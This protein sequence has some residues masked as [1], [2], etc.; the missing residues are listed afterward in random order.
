MEKITSC[1]KCPA[2]FYAPKVLEFQDFEKMPDQM[3]T[4]CSEVNDI[5]KAENCELVTNWHVNTNGDLDSGIGL[6]QG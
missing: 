6:K 2:G 5:G 3:F 1:Q 4:I